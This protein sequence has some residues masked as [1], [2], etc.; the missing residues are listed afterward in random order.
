MQTDGNAVLSGQQK[1]QNVP[2]GHVMKVVASVMDYALWSLRA[3]GL[4]HWYWQWQW[5]FLLALKIERWRLTWHEHPG[6]NMIN[7]KMTPPSLLVSSVRKAVRRT[8]LSLSLSSVHFVC[9]FKIIFCRLHGSYF[10]VELKIV[11]VQHYSVSLW[12][13]NYFCTGLLVKRVTA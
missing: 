11:S 4:G 6:M 9:W 13:Q 5:E 8:E 12:T 7:G 3:H 1:Q 2:A 10:V